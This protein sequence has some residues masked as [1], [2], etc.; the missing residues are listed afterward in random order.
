MTRKAVYYFGNL[1]VIDE[2]GFY[3][4]GK[5]VLAISF[6]YTIDPSR[7]RFRL[8]IVWVALFLEFLGVK[9]IIYD[10]LCPEQLH[11]SVDTYGDLWNAHKY[12]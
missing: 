2:S 1:P 5:N 3:F 12:S 9:R 6:L 10:C 8:I 7:P 4:L 11:R